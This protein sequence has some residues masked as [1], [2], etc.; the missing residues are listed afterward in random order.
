MQPVK[1]VMMWDLQEGKEQQ[2]VDFMVSEFGPGLLRLGL[3]LS[4]AWYTQA[5]AGSQIVLECLLDNDTAARSFLRS[6]EFG[7]LRAQLLEFA[8]DFRYRIVRPD[9]SGLTL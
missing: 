9:Y 5:G 7:E 6:S 2:G 4:E 3:R 1:L 8:V